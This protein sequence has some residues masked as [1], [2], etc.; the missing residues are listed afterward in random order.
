MVGVAVCECMCAGEDSG[1]VVGGCGV[2][3][4]TVL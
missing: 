3:L 4:L 2:C 1:M